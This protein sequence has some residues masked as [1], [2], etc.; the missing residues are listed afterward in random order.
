MDSAR[1][2]GASF[3]GR[4]KGEPFIVHISNENNESFTE[5]VNYASQ[6]DYSN[7][8]FNGNVID[9]MVSPEFITNNKSKM[10]GFI[11]GGL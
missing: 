10:V 6:L 1:G 7:N 4:K 5:I 3:D 11:K 2:F 9:F 8:K